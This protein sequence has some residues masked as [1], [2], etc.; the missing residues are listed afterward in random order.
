MKPLYLYFDMVHDKCSV[1]FSKF[2]KMKCWDFVE[3]CLL[4]TCTFGSER[5][6]HSKQQ[7]TAV[8]LE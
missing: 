6:K 7:Q 5:F 1:S 4:A 8:G 2:Y 3:F